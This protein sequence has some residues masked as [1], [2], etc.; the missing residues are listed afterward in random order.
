MKRVKIIVIQE[1]DI[2]D[3]GTVIVHPEDQ[4]ECVEIDHKYYMPTITWL[5]RAEDSDVALDVEANGSEDEAGAEWYLSDSA[6]E[7]F[8]KVIFEESVV[9]EW[10]GLPDKV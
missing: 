3:E 6:G 2:P 9:H 5:E 7:I 10:K 1:V 8:H 4:V